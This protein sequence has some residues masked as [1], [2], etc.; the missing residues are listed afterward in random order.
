MSDY[1]FVEVVKARDRMC[2]SFYCSVECPIHKRNNQ[3]EL[4]C[5]NFFLSFPKEAEEIIMGW[6]KEQE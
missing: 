6:E 5:S 2:N 4:T 3:K 1:S